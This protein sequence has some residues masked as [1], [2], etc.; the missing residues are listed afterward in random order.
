MIKD[1]D[2]LRATNDIVVL[3]PVNQIAD[4]VGSVG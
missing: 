3:Y 2:I 4:N 1:I